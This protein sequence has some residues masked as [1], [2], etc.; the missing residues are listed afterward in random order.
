MFIG[1][2]TLQ[3]PTVRTSRPPIGA[4]STRGQARRRRNCCSQ[5]LLAAR[6]ALHCTS[7][8]RIALH[9]RPDRIKVRANHPPS[10]LPS[11]PP[12]PIPCRMFRY[13]GPYRQS[14]LPCLA[15][16]APVLV[17]RMSC[18]TPYR[19]AHSFP[20][21]PLPRSSLRASSNHP[22]PSLRAYLS[23]TLEAA[24]VPH[25]LPLLSTALPPHNCLLFCLC[26]GS[27]TPGSLFFNN[28]LAVVVRF[29]TAHPDTEVF[30]LSIRRPYPATRTHQSLDSATVFCY[31][32]AVSASFSATPTL[33]YHTSVPDLN[34]SLCS[35]R[36]DLAVKQIHR[37]Q[38]SIRPLLP[39]LACYC[40]PNP[41]ISRS[42]RHNT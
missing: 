6:D 12:P 38:S 24:S 27:Q 28:K 7:V 11:P 21:P 41:V 30:R 17:C 31:C 1:I 5:E 34:L 10:C 18:T 32:R 16:P 3:T 15:S 33:L 23:T 42:V 26:F 36:P 25:L 37:D 39:R 2:S 40:N 14:T 22:P 29:H 35:T 13:N 19:T 4:A 20:S 8:H 9:R